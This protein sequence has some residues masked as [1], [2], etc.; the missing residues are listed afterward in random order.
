MEYYIFGIRLEESALYEAADRPVRKIK[1]SGNRS[2]YSFAKTIT[3]AF[4]FLFDHAFGF[5]DSFDLMNAQKVYELF[6]DVGEPS[7]PA[8]KGVKKTKVSQ[9]FVNPG[10]K[11]L[12]LFDYGDEWRFT[13][14][15]KEIRKAE[16]GESEPV[17]LESIG[18]SPEQYPPCEEDL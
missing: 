15:L 7:S 14:E 16:K 8:A 17:V 2:L 6:T 18:K 11:M 4:G 3:K 10:E 9:A 5:Y 12:F 13:V 1:I